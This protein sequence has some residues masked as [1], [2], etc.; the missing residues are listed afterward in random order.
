M[1]YLEA[2]FV[3]LGGKLAASYCRFR[4]NPSALS[5]IIISFFGMILFV[6][7]LWPMPGSSQVVSAF[8]FVQQELRKRLLCRSEA[9]L[10]WVSTSRWDTKFHTPTQKKKHVKL[11]FP[12]YKDSI[13]TNTLSKS[14]CIQAQWFE[15]ETLIGVLKEDRSTKFYL[16]KA[17]TLKVLKWRDLWRMLA[18]HGMP[19]ECRRFNM[20]VCFVVNS[21]RRWNDNTALV[22]AKY[23]ARQGTV[24]VSGKMQINL[25]GLWRECGLD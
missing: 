19:Q 25:L 21:G 23:D 15:E 8:E 9:L 6:I 16:F 7:I 12:K 18:F 22:S 5:H 4:R 2:L 10:I 11:Y 17:I 1:L 14:I 20:H 24:S 3:Q 13:R